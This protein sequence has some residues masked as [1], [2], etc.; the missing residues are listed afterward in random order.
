MTEQQLSPEGSEAAIA[1]IAAFRG[2]DR[3][4]YHSPFLP[5]W[6]E[7][8]EIQPGVNTFHD[9]LERFAQ[10]QVFRDIMADRERAL[11]R[12]TGGSK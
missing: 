6:K 1:I 4:W 11:Q 12:W 7:F 5:A 8:L 10:S 9:L 2:E 3:G